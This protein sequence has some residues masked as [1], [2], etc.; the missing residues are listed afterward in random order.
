MASIIVHPDWRISERLVTPEK[1]FLNRRDFLRRAGLT[2]AGLL[3]VPLSRQ[4]RAD[5]AAP[6]SP[7]RTNGVA[8]SITPS[9]NFPAP[10]NGEFN[11]NRALTSEK[12]AGHYNNFYEFSLGKDVY[13]YVDKFVTAPWPVQV[14][15]LV[16]KPMTLDATELVDMFG[17]EER[18]YRMRCVEAWA[19][20]VPWTGFQFSRLIEKV[21]PKPEAKFVRFETFNRPD[22]S[23]GMAEAPNYPWPYFEGL[24]LDEAMNPL[25]MMVTGIYGK[26]LPKQH[27][28]PIRMVVPWKYGYKSIKSVVK[29]EFITK[30]PRTFWET[31]QPE[32]YP[33][34]SN[35]NPNVPHPRWSQATE[36]IIDTGDRVKTLLYNGYGKYVAQLYSRA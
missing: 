18:V 8:A 28:A 19:M 16:E 24:R 35:V 11:P 5:S 10:R 23:P 26:P 6:A 36:R 13:R 9:K 27:G 22:Q 21:V 4:A 14:G 20:I 12:V 31:L 17:L 1:A 30:Q 29:I 33:F 25:T 34:E 2:G 7:A 32:E 3:A 15:G